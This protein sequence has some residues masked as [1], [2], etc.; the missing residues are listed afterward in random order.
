MPEGEHN[1]AEAVGPSS[2]PSSPSLP[3]KTSS[4]IQRPA[5]I[6]SVFFQLLINFCS[7]Y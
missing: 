6:Y 7:W 1:L 5:G 3:S 4:K 2:S